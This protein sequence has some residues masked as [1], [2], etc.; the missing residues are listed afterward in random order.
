MGKVV[1]RLNRGS[2]KMN[3]RSKLD[4]STKPV[5]IRNVDEKGDVSLTSRKKY[6]RFDSSFTNKEGNFQYLVGYSPLHSSSIQIVRPILTPSPLP[7]LLPKDQGDI[8]ELKIYYLDD[9]GNKK[10]KTYDA[11]GGKYNSAYHKWTDQWDKI[12]ES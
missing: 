10:V 11:R 3:V 6:G 5:L 7:T 1:R 4:N 8:M 12:L 2:G 9:E